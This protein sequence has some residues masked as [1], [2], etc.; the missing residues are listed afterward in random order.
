MLVVEADVSIK[1]LGYVAKEEAACLAPFLDEEEGL[2]EAAPPVHVERVELRMLSPP[3]PPVP[4]EEEEEEEPAVVAIKPN[5]DAYSLMPTSVTIQVTVRT[6]QEGVY[7]TLR[8][9][10]PPSAASRLGH[11]R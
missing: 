9:A 1:K 5:P 3:S 11:G 2:E 6:Q 7:M 4:M 10:F 8:Q